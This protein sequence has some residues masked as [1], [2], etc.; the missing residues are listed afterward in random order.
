MTGT[1]RPV[2]LITG[3]SRGVGAATALALA[4]RG[5]DLAL[6]YRNKA[7]RAAQVAAEASRIGSAALTVACDITRE[8]EVAALYGRVRKWRAQLDLLVLNASG[9]LERDLLAAD[10]G[11]PLHMNRDAQLAL[12]VGALPLLRPGGVVVF[13]TSHWA[14]LYGQVQQLPAYAPIAASKYA[15][16]QALRARQ[17]RLSAHG[18]RLI[19]VTG[20][21]IE[22][23]ITPRLLD[24]TAPGFTDQWR[25]GDGA[26][27]TTG[28]MGETIAAAALDAALPSGH[29]VVVGHPLSALPRL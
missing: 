6:V 5:H 8:A 28:D 29:V 26:L 10:P 19:V 13:V 4:A 3:G 27:P 23:T 18:V 21:V 1:G 14:H 16:E 15:G 11:Y 17:P 22:G 12:L 7:A 9:G 20:D 2:A 25:D 24:R